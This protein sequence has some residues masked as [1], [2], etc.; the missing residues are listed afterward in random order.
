MV[1]L[2]DEELW[3]KYQT[4]LREIYD[5]KKANKPIYPLVHLI[6][7]Y[8]K[9]KAM[10]LD[11]LVV[12]I[13]FGNGGTLEQLSG[14]YKVCYGFDI[15]PKNVKLTKNTFKEKGIQNV[16]F[17]VHNIMDP[18]KYSD[19]FDVMV[20][21]HVLEHFDSKEVKT[22]FNNIKTLLKKGGI[23]FGATPCNIP[24]N[25][26]ICPNCGFVFEIDGHKQIFDDRKISELLS[27]NGFEVQ[28]ARHFNP[29]HFYWGESF[30]FKLLHKI[31]EKKLST[32]LEFIAKSI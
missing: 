13:G 9:D 15:S 2:T 30:F 17:E 18:P 10:P 24:L 3:D 7:K 14:I 6:K 21:S 22:V 4:E 20:L 27:Q 31:Y 28:L 8:Y 25:P 29:E 32:Q 1:K 12:E 5:R 16:K 26:R 23:L 11:A 19:Y